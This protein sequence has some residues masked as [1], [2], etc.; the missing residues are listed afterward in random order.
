MVPIRDG[1]RRRQGVRIREGLGADS[2]GFI[3]QFCM[4]EVCDRGEVIFPEGQ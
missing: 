1:S 3:F 4:Y 2:L